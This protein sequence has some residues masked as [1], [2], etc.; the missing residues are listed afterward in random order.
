MKATPVRLQY[1]QYLQNDDDYDDN[2]GGD[3][4]GYDDDNGGYGDAAAAAKRSETNQGATHALI[5]RPEYLRR[6]L[7]AFCVCDLCGLKV[8]IFY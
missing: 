5:W 7:L 8:C 6:L 1:R 3:S 2:R 4:G